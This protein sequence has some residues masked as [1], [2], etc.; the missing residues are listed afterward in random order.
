MIQKIIIKKLRVFDSRVIPK[1]NVT[2]H[3]HMMACIYVHMNDAILRDV[4]TRRQ[5]ERM[6]PFDIL[7][8]QKICIIHCEN[9]N[10][11]LQ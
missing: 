10:V 3:M 5:G 4:F 11:C 2:I 8:A 7:F 1:L 6:C 9:E